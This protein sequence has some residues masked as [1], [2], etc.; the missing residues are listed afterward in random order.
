MIVLDTT[1]D[2]LQVVL[3]FAITTNQLQCVA[4]YRDIT[5]TGYTPWRVVTNTN[6]TTDVNLVTA[7]A[8][9]TQRVIDSVSIYNNDTM[10]A[11]VTIKFDA[12]GTEYILQKTNLAPWDRLEYND[13][14]GWRCTNVWG[15]L[16]TSMVMGN[17]S[18][19]STS[20][21]QSVVDTDKIITT[22]N[23]GTFYKIDGL[24][25]KMDWLKKYFVRAVIIY[26]MSSTSDGTAITIALGPMTWTSNRIFLKSTKPSSTTAEAIAQMTGSTGYIP[27]LATT[28]ATQ[29][30]ARVEW[31]IVVSTWISYFDIYIKNDTISGVI[32]IRKGSHIMYNEVV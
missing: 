10:N 4:T 25:F 31:M 17:S 22:D 32:T 27:T 11:Q 21:K 14:T 16:K 13:A 9:S 20:R 24:S 1:T 23:T 19:S 5:T 26:T 3:W 28:S 18:T 6:S 2:N 15:A 29:N 12:N 30:V 8:A 7:P